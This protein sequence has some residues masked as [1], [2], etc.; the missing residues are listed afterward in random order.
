MRYDSEHK[1]RT[2]ERLLKAAAKAIRRDGAEKVGVAAV[3][4]EAGLTHG[5][6]YA[7]FKSRDELVAEGVAQMFRESR[8]KLA[9]SVAGRTPAQG[10]AEYIGFYLSPE[11]RDSRTSGCPLPFLGADAPRLPEAARARFAAGVKGLE[12]AIAGLLGEMGWSDPEAEAGSLVAELVGALS[13][14]RAEPDPVRSDQMLRRSRDR[15]IR[16]F[17]LA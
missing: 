10:L 6:F 7:H 14:A 5:G 1:Q 11:H 15:L 3:M 13:L 17:A 4:A 12:D 16:R 9:N 8:E 2:R